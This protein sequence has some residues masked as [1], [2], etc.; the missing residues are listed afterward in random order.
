M[1]EGK[2]TAEYLEEEVLVIQS[3]RNR[4]AIKLA[5]IMA[6]IQEKQTYK[7]YG[8]KDMYSYCRDRFKL[9]KT[10]VT[11]YAIVGKTYGIKNAD[12]SYNIPEKFYEY[13]AEKLYRIS[14]IPGFNVTKF[15]DITE[16]FGINSKLTTTQIKAIVNEIKGKKTLNKEE[17]LQMTLSSQTTKLNDIKDL[18]SNKSVDDASFRRL[19]SK[20]VG[21]D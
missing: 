19:V 5:P 17:Y 8:Y 1:L 21:V 7:Q 13:G 4:N 11:V 20:I 12:G 2:K 16:Q 15:E 14:L 18:C 9:S 6:E 3:G 10:Q